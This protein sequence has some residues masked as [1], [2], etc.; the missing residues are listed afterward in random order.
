MSDDARTPEDVALYQQGRGPLR[1]KVAEGG[2][3]LSTRGERAIVQTDELPA[4]LTANLSST[5]MTTT[6]NGVPASSLT[7]GSGEPKAL[8]PT[9]AFS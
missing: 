9:I 7:C 8:P 4:Y 3:F 5:G 2:V 6:V 1:S